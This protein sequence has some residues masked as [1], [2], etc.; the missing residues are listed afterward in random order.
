MSGAR[1]LSPANARACSAALGCNRCAGERDWQGMVANPRQPGQQMQPKTAKQPPAS[2][3]PR[4]L[5]AS[6]G[7]AAG[8]CGAA[9]TAALADAEIRSM[10]PR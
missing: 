3:M 6:Y 7:P 4:R 9:I 5:I 2:A 1:W 8:R 10:D